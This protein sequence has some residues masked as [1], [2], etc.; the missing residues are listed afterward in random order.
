[1][2]PSWAGSQTDRVLGQRCPSA[3]AVVAEQLWVLQ[4]FWIF[5]VLQ[6]FVVSGPHVSCRQGP[7]TGAC[8]FVWII[9]IKT[10]NMQQLVSSSSL[11]FDSDVVWNWSLINGSLPHVNGVKDRQ[12]YEEGCLQIHVDLGITSGSVKSIRSS[13][14]AT[15]NCQQLVFLPW[16][17]LKVRFREVQ[18]ICTKNKDSRGQEQTAAF[19]DSTKNNKRE[20]FSWLQSSIPQI[21]PEW[22]LLT[23]KSIKDL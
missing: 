9:Y 7:T 17:H 21:C 23:F 18:I 15:D 12:Q 10:W 19:S 3:A 8:V 1:M 5:Q 6:R 22:T 11:G 16:W 2:R 4:G 14:L 13:V 20:K